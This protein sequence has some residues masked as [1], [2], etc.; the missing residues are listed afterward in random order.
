[1]PGF[2][3]TV[4]SPRPV[5]EDAMKISRCLLHLGCWI[6]TGIVV[7]LSSE[8]YSQQNKS[9]GAAA[10]VSEEVPTDIIAAQIRSQGF[11]CDHPETA[12][13]DASQSKPDEAAW[14][15]TCESSS[16][17]VTLIPHEAAK[18][19]QVRPQK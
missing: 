8:A 4:V 15:L 10:P 19:Q 6:L 17:R 11:V 16:Y 12:T 18:V 3:V 7:S 9:N 2:A 14:L 5:L 13:R 1:M